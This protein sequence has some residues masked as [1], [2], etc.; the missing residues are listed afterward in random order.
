MMTLVHLHNSSWWR[1]CLFSLLKK[2]CLKSWERP[3][4]VVLYFR[5]LFAYGNWTIIDILW[6]KRFFHV[7]NVSNTVLRKFMTDI[8]TYFCERLII[9]KIFHL[10]H[11]ITRTALIRNGNLIL[12]LKYSKEHDKK[13]PIKTFC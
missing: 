9:I 12:Q 1:Y 6:R 8:I 13:I 2:V 4:L 3:R 11:V 5:F 7:I 10:N